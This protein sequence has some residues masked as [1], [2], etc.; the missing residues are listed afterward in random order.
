MPHSPYTGTLI[1][2][3]LPIAP[4]LA[5]FR[6][7][8]GPPSNT[9]FLGPTQPTTPNGILIASIGRSSTIHGRYGYQR[10]DLQNDDVTRPVRI[11]RLRYMC[12]AA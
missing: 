12:D 2:L 5:P 9:S 7:G 6:V 10:T 1:T 4:K 3:C 8:F 11:G